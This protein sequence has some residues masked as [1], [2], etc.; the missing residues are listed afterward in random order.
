MELNAAARLVAS[1]QIT[2][3]FVVEYRTKGQ[4]GRQHPSQHMDVGAHK[5]QSVAE[6]AEYAQK[7]LGPNVEVIDVKYTG[8]L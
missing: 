2:A 3:N 7:R 8:S 4:N 5:A 1:A 6:A